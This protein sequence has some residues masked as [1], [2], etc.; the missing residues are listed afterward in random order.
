LNELAAALGDD[1]SFSTTVTNSIATKLPLAGGTMTGP[2]T[3]SQS[4]ALHNQFTSTGGTS[5]LS[6]I[7]ADG[8]QAY[9]NYSGATNEMSAGYDRTSSSF[10]FANADT[11][12]SAIRMQINSSGNV[13]I[14]TT[15]PTSPLDVSGV[16]TSKADGAVNDAQIG[17]L[18]FTNTN[19]NASSNP[20]RASIL[21]GRQNSAWGGYLSLYTSTG[22]DA[23]TEKVRIGETGN[24]GIG[25]S[26]LTNNTL[27]KTTYFGN[28][29][30]S[31]TG[32]SSQARF[33]LGNNWYYNSGDKFI[34]T[35]YANLYT[36]QSG[37]HQFLTSTASGSA[38][39]AAT[40]TNVLTIDSSGAV[41][42]GT[43][44]PTAPLH[45]DAAGMGDIY[46][47]L[48]QNS[49]T[50][51]DHYNV[52][53][54]MQGA[55]GSATGYIGTGGAT[56]GNTSFRNNFVIGTQSTNNLVF[57]TYD[58]ERMRIDTSGA[59]G[60]GTTSPTEK[61][62]VNGNSIINGRAAINKTAL[63]SAVA[64]T[65]NSDVSSTTSYGL[66][67]CNATSNTRFLVD[68]VGNSSF[69]GSDNSLTVR[70]TSDNKVGI[71]TTSPDQP[72]D[73]SGHAQIGDGG[74]AVLLN[75]NA[76]SNAQLKL[77]NAELMRLDNSGQVTLLGYGGSHAYTV[78]QDQSLGY[79]NNLNAGSFGILHRAAYD[80]YIT[81]NTYYYKSA[82]QSGWKA[83]YGAYKSTVLGM[84]NGEFS[85]DC[86]NAAPGSN[87]A[88]VSGLANIV[89][90]N[91]DGITMAAG[92]GISFSPNSNASG[93]SSE[94]LDDY[95]EGTWTPTVAGGTAGYSIRTGLYTKIGNIVRLRC[96]I[97]LGSWSGSSNVS[98]TGLPF[99]SV[100]TAYNHDWG[101]IHLENK[102]NS[103]VWVVGASGSTVFFR[104]QDVAS[105]DAPL[106][107]TD[108]DA[109]T[110]IMFTV[111][112]QTTA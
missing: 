12:S 72:L 66:E 70:F 44:S 51:T 38:G 9:I 22:T 47:G 24:V 45:I 67:V 91:S 18:N 110:G 32:D 83:K 54:F 78:P 105:A 106:A 14:G 29:T 53:R 77:S 101:A 31:I 73:V 34:G 5:K 79:T 61:L 111:V 13:G 87:G 26:S 21:S 99:A 80:S 59:V 103:S 86:S 4:G 102:P 28:S 100:A 52:V 57:N 36:Q 64:L 76:T 37:T 109:N 94:T 35:G 74:G 17:R 27:G 40:F 71:G 23:A 107:H 108:I 42:I 89:K 98:I 97:K 93:M 33:W 43:S 41:G 20:I 7:S 60:I 104:R 88:A 46:S 8:A 15:S 68:G 55:S 10:R 58:A 75:F 63:H 96:S 6:I 1:A 48:I 82:G 92:K 95:E 90:I 112:Y 2:I 19:S 50:D 85:F 25:T 39:Q 49:T 16:I 56:V 30:S 3:M 11:L 65:I 62:H 81:G 84:L 69:Y